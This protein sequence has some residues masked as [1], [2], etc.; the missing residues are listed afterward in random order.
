MPA[1]PR[2]Y[3]AAVLALVAFPACGAPATTSAPPA[4]PKAQ[5]D[6]PASAKPGG[7]PQGTL[8]VFDERGP[9]PVCAPPKAECPATQPPSAFLDRCRLAGFRIQKCG[10]DL[11]CTGDVSAL[12][13]HY[14]AA[15]QLTECAPARTDCSPPQASAAFQDGCSEH[16][17]RLEV[18]G[19]EWLCSGNFRK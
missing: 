3:A 19:C 7:A 6:A 11:R 10:C 12:A 15:G 17:Y 2:L 13:R 8:K 16:G 5:V 4:P 18:C 9:A 1:S 14:N